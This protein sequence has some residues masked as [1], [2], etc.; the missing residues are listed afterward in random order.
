MD[1]KYLSALCRNNF[2][3]WLSRKIDRPLLP[4]DMVQV[5]FTFDC[6]LACVMCSMRKQKKLLQSRG[7]RTEIDSDTFKKVIRESK[8]LGVNNI[9]FIGGE[10]FLRKDLFNLV[11]YAKN[12]NL[13][14]IIVTNGVL[15]DENNAEKC[16]AAGV[17]WLSVSIDAAEEEAFSKIRGKNILRE[18]IKNIEALNELKK[19]RKKEFPKIVAVCT[20]MNDNLEQLSD[21][22]RLAK[23]LGIERIIFQP[24][25]TNNAD[26]SRRDSDGSAFIPSSRFSVLDK[27]IGDLTAYKKSSPE[28]FNF[29]AN[30]FKH[31]KLSGEY[32]K[33]PLKSN[34]WPCYAGYNRLQITQDYKVYFCIPPNKNVDVSFGDVS[35]D[36]LRDIWYSK[37]AKIR[38]KLIRGC[39]APCMQWCSYRD[40]FIEL[41]EIFQKKLLFKRKVTA[42]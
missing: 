28:N 32:L 21:V 35:R 27:A 12:F 41:L 10:P 1:I 33:K 19:E 15:L 25:V 6:N 18:I 31:L 29:I 2:L 3:F 23:K 8:E 7:S 38:R 26:Q 16:F 42:G 20:I 37:E 40:S 13:N 11:S 14:T 24:V 9:L 39:N 22:A 17:D 5:N 4:P 30:S 36:S 34:I